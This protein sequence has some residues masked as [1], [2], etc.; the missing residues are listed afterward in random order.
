M[1]TASASSSTPLMT[2]APVSRMRLSRSAI[3]PTRRSRSAAVSSMLVSWRRIS[4]SAMSAWTFSGASTRCS[5]TSITSLSS[6][7]TRM[8]TPEQAAGFSCRVAQ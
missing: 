4:V 2:C 5:M 3:T 1:A 6:F 8:D 7:S